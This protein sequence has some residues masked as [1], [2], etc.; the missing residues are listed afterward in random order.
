[1]GRP[2]PREK[3]AYA[4]KETQSERS[5]TSAKKE[6]APEKPETKQEKT[7]DTAEKAEEKKE[8]APSEVLPVPAPSAKKTPPKPVSPKPA[9]TP[10]KNPVQA[11]PKK[12]AP[13]KAKVNLANKDQ[14]VSSV[15]D[16][17]NKKNIPN[18]AEGAAFAETYGEELT[19]TEM[20]V[21]NRHM[22]RFWNMP[23]GNKDAYNMI[24]EVELFI[25]Q[26]SI[27]KK[28]SIV[29]SARFK[30]DPEFR[31]AAESALRAVLD[32]E[33]SPLPLDPAKYESWKHMIF[34]FDPREMSQ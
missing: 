26:D 12:G 6:P 28:A 24:V 14:A 20:D 4:P 10:K 2:K 9:P 11:S 32:P 13:H 22:K 5:E 30:K 21:L 3:Q 8:A 29:D 15:G 27:I 16:F 19:G 18:G 33:C 17:L 1:M 23:S 34:V 7:R 25:G 31:I